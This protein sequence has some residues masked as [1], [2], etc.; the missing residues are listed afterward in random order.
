MRAAGAF[1][2]HL[3]QA[4]LT[5]AVSRLE[6]ELFGSLALTGR[7]HST[8][9]AVLLGLMGEDSATYD[10]TRAEAKLRALRET[11]RLDL[12]GGC[13]VPFVAARDLIFTPEFQRWH[14]NTLRF[15]AFLPG[16]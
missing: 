1:V 10:A 11:S 9:R 5:G 15:R 7:G 6:V 12:G 14:A 8:D 2:A 4:G 16:T 3:R 13:A